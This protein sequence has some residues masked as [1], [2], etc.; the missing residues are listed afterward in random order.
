MG[1]L[2]K[3]TS[4]L[5]LGWWNCY[6]CTVFRSFFVLLCFKYRLGI[7]FQCDDLIHSFAP[8]SLSTCHRRAFKRSEAVPHPLIIYLYPHIHPS[9]SLSLP[10]HQVKWLSAP[11]RVHPGCACVHESLWANWS[12]IRF[13]LTLQW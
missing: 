10:H 3:V 7:P 5:K 4:V 9:C 6:F 2:S 13:L 12:G 11:L 8:P 1:R